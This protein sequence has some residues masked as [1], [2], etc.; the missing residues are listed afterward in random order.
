[1]A[2]DFVVVGA[3]TA[4]AVLASRLSEDP[5][6][7]VLLLE[8][9]PDLPDPDKMPETLRYADHPDPARDHNWTLPIT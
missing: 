9:G 3:G 6:T 8:A 1:V 5:G 4:G 7:Q 2:T